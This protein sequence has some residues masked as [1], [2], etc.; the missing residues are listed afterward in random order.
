MVEKYIIVVLLV[1]D[2]KAK[3]KFISKSNCIESF[4][5]SLP[6]CSLF[7]WSKWLGKAD[8]H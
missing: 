8:E 1:W 6:L 7:I 5:L 2:H 3:K 4:I